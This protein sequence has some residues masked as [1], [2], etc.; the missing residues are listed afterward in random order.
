MKRKLFCEL[1]PVCYEISLRKEFLLR[2]LKHLF[3]G[4][5]FAYYQQPDHPL[6]YIVKSHVSPLIRRLHGVDLQLQY[7]KAHNLRLAAEKVN[8]IVIEPGET[9]SFLKLIGR[10]TEEKGYKEALTISRKGLGSAPGGGLCQLANLIHWLVLNSPLEVTE[11]H[12]H[13]DSLFPDERRRVP[14]GTGT[15]VFYNNVDYQFKNNSNQAVQ[16]LV[17]VT[18]DD[19]CGELRSTTPFPYKYRIV[20]EG[21]CFRQETDGWFRCSKIYREAYDDQRNLVEKKLILDN[22]S[23]VLY[24]PALIPQDQILKEDEACT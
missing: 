24:A 2:N 1:H 8:G 16:L 20:E 14:F 9:F 7:N 12:H 15:S 18:E 23:R 6:P 4:Q 22:H 19:L 5:R 13:S 3:S 17:W 21:H 11:L 10:A